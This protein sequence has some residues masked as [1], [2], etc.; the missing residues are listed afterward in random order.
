MG[1]RVGFFHPTVF[2]Y[3]GSR[4]K[5]VT[6]VFRFGRNRQRAGQCEPLSIIGWPVSTQK[7]EEDYIVKIKS[8]NYLHVCTA[9]C[10]RIPYICLIID[11]PLFTLTMLEVC[12][13]KAR[14]DEIKSNTC[15]FYKCIPLIS[16]PKSYDDVW[17][18]LPRD[19]LAD[20]RPALSSFPSGHIHP[21][22][23]GEGEGWRPLRS[24][25]RQ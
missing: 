1:D 17:M 16:W 11:F 4:M 3:S 13:V 9:Y 19:R 25:R 15:Y 6:I 18:A 24:G 14:R 10:A 23:Q 21:I 5:S 7:K 20:S 8:L 22:E 12:I 2:V